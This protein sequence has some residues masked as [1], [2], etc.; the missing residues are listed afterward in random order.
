MTVLERCTGTMDEL[1]EAEMRAEE[2]T[3]ASSNTATTNA[4]N[5]LNALSK[6][7]RWTAWIFQVLAALTV[8]QQTFDFVHNDLHTNNIMWVNTEDEYLYYHI[9]GA[10]GG[11]RT[12]R[13]PTFGR[14]F[15]IIDFGRATF[16]VPGSNAGGHI[17]F[18][19]AYAPDGDAH[20]QYNF[21][22][23]YDASSP[24]LG[25]NKSFD[26]CRLAVAMLETLWEPLHTRRRAESEFDLPKRILTREPGH[27]Q[28]ETASPL[29]NLMWLWL[30]DDE[31]CNVL[32]TSSGSTRYPGFDLYTAIARDVH[33]AVP[34]QQLTLPLFDSAFRMDTAPAAGTQVWELRAQIVTAPSQ[35]KAKAKGNGNGKGT[36]PK[37]RKE[38]VVI[39]DLD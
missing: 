2:D 30:I 27:I 18:P 35:A 19:D 31:G 5:A 28:Y 26:L 9:A 12:Y 16:R 11:D 7:E 13:V 3:D 23:Y 10:A 33:N 36:G 37:P 22:P 29:W 17:W 21:G 25:P 1:M 4:L 34:A 32:R 20:D 38:E 15:K 6:E 8:A 14:L 24:K 39:M